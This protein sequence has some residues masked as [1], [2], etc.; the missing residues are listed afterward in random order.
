MFVVFGLLVGYSSYVVTTFSNTKMLVDQFLD[1]D[2][3]MIT[4]ISSEYGNDW[5][6]GLSNISAEYD[7]AR[8]LLKALI[9]A[10]FK[11]S[12]IIKFYYRR[13]EDNF[14]YLLRDSSKP[15]QNPEK[16]EG[17]MVG[18]LE[19]VLK[20]NLIDVEHSF[21]NLNS[22]RIIYIN[23]TRPGDSHQYVVRI[24]I[25]RENLLH[26]ILKNSDTWLVY[27]TVTLLI[28]LVLGFIFAK[29]ISIPIR[30]L[31]EGATALSRGDLNIRFKIKRRDNIG[32]LSGAL[33]E[34]AINIENRIRTIETMNKIDKAVNSAISRRQLLEYVAGYI[35]ELFEGSAVFIFEKGSKSYKILAVSPENYQFKK[36]EILFTNISEKYYRND[37]NI[38]FFN[39]ESLNHIHKI[40]T[41]S[42]KLKSGVS[43]PL[44][45]S[46]RLAGLL[47]VLMDHLDERSIS[48]LESLADQVSVALLSL[49]ESDDKNKMYNGMLLSLTRSVDTKSRW[50]AGHSERVTTHAYNLS[51]KLGLDKETREM[52]RISSLLHDIGK[53]GIPENI[54]D[55]PGKLDDE[56]F[57]LIRNHPVMGEEIIKDIPHFKMVRAVVRSHHE[58]WD[59]RG[60]PDGIK[61][62]TIPLAARIVAIADVWDAIT[63]DR[64]YRKGFNYNKAVE[65]MKSERGELFDPALLD[66]F[67]EIIDKEQNEL[68]G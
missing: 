25:N 53:L 44:I 55:K 7:N 26:F 61:K 42:G 51:R 18:E 43:I 23:V 63:A 64:P 65:I 68:P 60:Y 39:E 66:L 35:S 22:S 33:N 36:D 11:D 40:V 10:E 47:V 13:S 17:D 8:D 46:D 37:H 57:L 38:Y 3:N 15:R 27:T 30:K 48:S 6:L 24:N 16:V 56:E 34:M 5:M 14:W 12:I 59:G 21:F 49:K 62:D 31:S 67:M 20:L 9:P 54:L 28:S 58:R 32:E 45:Q 29:S 2:Q 50:T 1:T 41:N 4:G 19:K 52:I